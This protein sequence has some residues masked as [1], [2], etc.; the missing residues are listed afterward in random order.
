MSTRNDIR[1]IATHA[2]QKGWVS[3]IEPTIGGRIP[4][5]V[6]TTPHGRMWVVEAKQ[7]R[8]PLHMADI[9]Q[10]VAFR[11][12]VRREVI[13][14][15]P[16]IPESDINAAIIVSGREMVTEYFASSAADVGI[17]L[18]YSDKHGVDLAADFLH[19]LQTVPTADTGAR[20]PMWESRALPILRYVAE[21]E[22]EGRFLSVRDIADAT[23]I[24]P[25]IVA[26]ELDRLVEGGY[27]AGEFQK[28]MSGGDPN[29]WF[30]TAPRL[31]P[32][33]IQG[34]G[35]DY[36]PRSST[37]ERDR[38]TT[39]PI[40]S[41]IDIQGSVGQLNVGERQTVVN[42]ESNLTAMESQGDKALAEALR[43]LSEAAVGDRALDDEARAA[44]LDAIEEVSNATEPSG[45]RRVP[46][47]KRAIEYIA[48][49]ANAATALRKSWEE[50][51]PVLAEY[52]QRLSHR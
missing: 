45:A 8:R 50:Y 19:Y 15:N 22:T 52:L 13:S 17:S 36:G 16:A 43:L 5:L 33:G 3:R 37:R 40:V 42:I 41:H 29:P 44:V 24:E 23:G 25:R 12:A 46:R 48:T 10:V 26:N 11:N 14:Q 32:R 47:I 49:A 9:G 28:L 38:S 27:I 4:D 31:T 18:Y 6:L 20:Y 2:K 7:R 35:G 30:L 34:L 51:G 21:Q 1:D 39:E